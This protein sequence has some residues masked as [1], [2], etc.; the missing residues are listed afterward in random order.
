MR[1]ILKDTMEISELEAYNFKNHLYGGGIFIVYGMCI[2]IGVLRHHFRCLLRQQRI[3]RGKEREYIPIKFHADDCHNRSF[4]GIAM[5]GITAFGILCHLL[6]FMVLSDFSSSD[7][8][9]VT[10]YSCYLIY[11]TT[12]LMT[13]YAYPAPHGIHDLASALAFGVEL[14][15]LVPSVYSKNTLEAQLNILSVVA[16]IFA[17]SG[18]A[19]E[20]AK[21]THP[22]AALVKPLFCVVKG[23]WL[24]HVGFLLH[25]PFHDS[26]LVK[27]ATKEPEEPKTADFTLVTSMFCWHVAGAFV[28]TLLVARI[29]ANMVYT[30]ARGEQRPRKVEFMNKY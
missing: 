11:G 30:E 25:N 28:I 20:C 27:A 23:S 16:C 17:L 10:M 7:V 21:K 6:G 22:T 19:I 29:V 4:I 8:S 18:I 2:M 9:H 12:E 5:V 1:A 13:A 26:S 24:I 15:L 3:D 14:V